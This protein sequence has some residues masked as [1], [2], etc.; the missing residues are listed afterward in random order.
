MNR[1]LR[2]WAYVDVTLPDN[3]KRGD[4]KIVISARVEN[5]KTG[6]M[7]DAENVEVKIEALREIERN[8]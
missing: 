8:R 4:A 6:V 7:L 3:W 1:L 2:V 5:P